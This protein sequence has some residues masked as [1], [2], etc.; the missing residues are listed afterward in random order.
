VRDVMNRTGALDE[1]MEQARGL[2]ARAKNCL[3]S[4]P[5]NPEREA[6]AILADYA[7]DRSL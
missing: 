3:S 1:A 4:L 7:V 6:L 2:V 5:D